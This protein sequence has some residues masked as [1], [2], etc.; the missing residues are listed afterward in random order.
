MGPSSRLAEERQQGAV[1][2]RRLLLVNEMARIGY[3][4]LLQ[5]LRKQS[6]HPISEVDADAAVLHAV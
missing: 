6:F 4:E 1:D 2:G 5:A 3:H